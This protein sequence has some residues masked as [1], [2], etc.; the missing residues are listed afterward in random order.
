MQER[1]GEEDGGKKNRE[2]AGREGGTTWELEEEG[3]EIND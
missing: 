3:S 1:G 2:A